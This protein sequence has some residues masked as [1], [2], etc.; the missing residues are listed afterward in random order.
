MS[1]K[2]TFSS[3]LMQNYKQ[4]EIVAPD[5]QFEALQTN[6]GHSL[7]FSIGTNNVFYLTKEL[8]D[9]ATGWQK[10]DLSSTLSQY[11][12]GL[13]VVAKTFAVS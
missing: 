1:V 12:N 2:I 13:P 7:L 5:T 8:V 9:H 10:T 11:H 3:E 6:E 4:A